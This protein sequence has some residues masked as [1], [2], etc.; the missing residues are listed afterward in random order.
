MSF[1]S[2]PFLISLSLCLS[3]SLISFFLILTGFYSVPIVKNDAN[4][5]ISNAVSLPIAPNIF[6][7]VSLTSFFGFSHCNLLFVREALKISLLLLAWWSVHVNENMNKNEN[8]NEWR[9]SKK[10]NE[11]IPQNADWINGMGQSPTPQIGGRGKNAI[12]LNDALALGFGFQRAEILAAF[13]SALCTIILAL[14]LTGEAFAES[15]SVEIK[16]HE[17][18]ADLCRLCFSSVCTW[19]FFRTTFWFPKNLAIFSPRSINLYGMFLHFGCDSLRNAGFVFLSFF[20][21]R[22]TV[23]IR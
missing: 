17:F 12:M 14:F 5:I 2:S 9:E 4:E 3:Y 16:E 8:E 23:S 11:I 13:T 10:S 15:L 20:G 18:F 7:P 21:Q 1:H 6:F 22:Y 19:L